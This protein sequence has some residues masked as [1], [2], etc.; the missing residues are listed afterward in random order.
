MR[1]LSFIILFLACA[2]NSKIYTVKIN[3]NSKEERSVIANHFPIDFVEKDSVYITARE[4][5]ICQVKKIFEGQY[6]IVK[7][8]KADASGTNCP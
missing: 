5:Q 3:A 7:G 6:K 4:S 2:Q 1:K 8:P